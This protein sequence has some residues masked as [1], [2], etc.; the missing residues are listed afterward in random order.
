M[1][2]HFDTELQFAHTQP[3]G[4]VVATVSGVPGVRRVE[5]W[6][7]EAASLARPDGLRIVRTYPDGGHGSLRLQAVPRQ[8]AFL[9][10]RIIAGHWL[11]TFNSDGVVVNEQALSMFPGLRIGDRIHLIVRG[12]PAEPRVMGVVREHLTQATVYTSPEQFEQE[13]GEPGLTEGVRVALGNADER[14]ADE[15]IASIERAL[16]DSGV[17]VTQSVSQAQLGRALGG[18]LFILIFTLVVMSMLMTTVGVMGLGSAMT[19]SVLERTRE[20]AVMR[21]IGA[22]A[23]T[24]RRS[25]VGEAVLVGALS[26]GISLVLSVPLTI[27]VD[28]IVG[29]ASFRPALGTGLSAAAMPLW[30]AIIIAGAVAASAYPAWKASKLTIREAL[31]FQ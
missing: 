27:F 5:P 4:T 9:S 20:F 23:G 30:L 13:T 25:V 7:V 19:I 1:E 3:E 10:P 14:S 31:G 17:K 11:S 8:S 21:V 22:T 28:W 18:H 6:S 26:A 16:D 12:A 2:R 24:I 29:T 15:I